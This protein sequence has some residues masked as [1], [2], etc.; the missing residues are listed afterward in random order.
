MLNLFPQTSVTKTNPI[1]SPCAI[2]GRSDDGD[3]FD[4]TRRWVWTTVWHVLP[5]YYNLAA[6]PAKIKL[7]CTP[8]CGAEPANKTVDLLLGNGR[9]DLSPGPPPREWGGQEKQQKRNTDE[10]KPCQND[11]TL[12]GHSADIAPVINLQDTHLVNSCTPP[13]REGTCFRSA[14]SKLFGD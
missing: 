3:I 1:T 13:S 7:Y 10:I 11:K 6:F 9:A 12:S 4:S 8:G 5:L 14:L 2:L